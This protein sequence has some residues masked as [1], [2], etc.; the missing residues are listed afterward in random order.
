MFYIYRAIEFAC[1]IRF[2]RSFV[3][4]PNPD[5][6]R[7]KP[8][9]VTYADAGYHDEESLE[10]IPVMLYAGGLFGG[11]YQA[12]TVDEI[13]KKYRVRILFVDRPGMGGTEKVPLDQRVSTWLG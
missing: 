7:H 5:K 13:A 11:R 4:S 2:H 8:L 10:D 1:N 6:G 12:L 9:R 3:L